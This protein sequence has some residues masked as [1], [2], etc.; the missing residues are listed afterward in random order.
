MQEITKARRPVA[1]SGRFRDEDTTGFPR[2]HTEMDE[3]ILPGLVAKAKD[4]FARGG[5]DHTLGAGAAE[6]GVERLCGAAELA[7]THHRG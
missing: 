6:R 1:R 5:S 2:F 3:E 7:E 4:E